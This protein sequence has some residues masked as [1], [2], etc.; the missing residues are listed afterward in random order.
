MKKIIFTLI[1]IVS[2]TFAAI[3]TMEGLF[4]NSS[5][6]D[7]DKEVSVLIF[8]A[9]V[10]RVINEEEQL[11]VEKEKE[12]K[13]YKYIIENKD[14]G[15]AIIARY[16]NS[17][18]AIDDLEKVTILG[19]GLVEEISTQDV[20]T[21]RLVTSLVDMYARNSSKAMLTLLKA[22]NPE[23]KS[24]QEV[25]NED[26][27]KL[28]DTYKEY[29]VKKKELE[30]LSKEVKEEKVEVVE[31]AVSNDSEPLISPMLPQE[32][33]EKI[34]V[35]ELVAASMYKK[36]ENIKLSKIGTKFFWELGLDG[37]YAKF[38]NEDHELKHLK[39]G[40]TEPVEVVV[41]DYVVFS[42]IY[43][44]PKKLIVTN[45]NYV[46]ELD[47]INF[48]TIKKGKTSFDERINDYKE[49][50]AKIPPKEDT[51]VDEMKNE[52][53][54]AA[55][56]SENTSENEGLEL[57]SGSEATVPVKVEPINFDEILI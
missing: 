42:G 37:I 24:N 29:L 31:G 1:F 53:T 39:L 18:M 9:G 56:N 35:Q 38:G 7:N 55:D 3:P 28:L 22:I 51:V 5:S 16:K 57:T 11:L 14:G 47:V 27:K 46:L 17:N 50:A 13:F 12:Y 32:E 21:K 10:T 45:N 15:R 25:I 26:K 23:F 19:E 34:R 2:N 20:L 6:A 44:L 4:R 36:S 30:K 33:E 52:E 54:I 40:I 49:Y 43:N 8:K 41:D 48:F